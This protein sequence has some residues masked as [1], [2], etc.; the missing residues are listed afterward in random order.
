VSL[1]L[2]LKKLEIDIAHMGLPYVYAKYDV[3]KS[4]VRMFFKE[5][6]QM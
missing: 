3:T 2:W 6:P 1:V 4:A 5:Y